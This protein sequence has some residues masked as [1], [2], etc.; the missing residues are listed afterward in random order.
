MLSFL[1]FLI[2]IIAILTSSYFI[3][4]FLKSKKFFN[5]LIFYILV[6][7]SQVIITFELLSSVKQINPTGILIINAI[8][9]IST[10]IYWKFNNS[11][12]IKLPDLH[13]VLNKIKIALKRD[14]IL[15]WLF[16]LLIVSSL[17]SLFLTLATP[18]NSA[19][20]L[21][22]HL[23]R[24]KF[25]LQNQSLLHYE[26][27][28]IRQ[29][30]FPINSEILILWSMVFLKRDFLAQLPEYLSYIGCL[31]LIF[32]FLSYLKFSTRRT[33]WTILI[34][35]SM[36]AVILESMSCQTNLIMAFLLLSSLYLF[37][38]GVKEKQKL[39]LIFS[40]I[41]YSIALGTKN[42]AFLF[43]PV[44]GIIFSSISIKENKKDFYKPLI[45]F[46]LA[47]I[48]TFIIL[49]SYNYILN[50]FDYGNPFSPS[51]FM[52]QH[53][54]GFTTKGFITNIIK[55]LFVF[56]D[57]TGLKNLEWTNSLLLSFKDNFLHLLGL[58][59]KDGL[60]FND[61][62][63]MNYLIHE[64]YSMY[65]L[66]GFI[67]YLPLVIKAIFSKNNLNKDKK[68][69]IKLSGYIFIGFLISIS[70]LMGFCLWFNRFFLTAIVLSAP[71]FVY[72]YSKENT[73]LKITITIIAGLNLIFIPVF[74]QS[75]PLLP[76]ISG[77]TKYNYT[78]FRNELRLRSD[79][80]INKNIHVSQLI[81]YLRKEAPNNSKIALVSFTEEFFYPLFE[82]NLTWKIYP[83]RYD[84]FYKRKNYN[85]YDFI[86]LPDK[87]QRITVPFKGKI[88]YKYSIKDNQIIY[89]DYNPKE[90]FIIYNDKNIKPI[91]SG[92]PETMSVLINLSEIPANFKL[93]KTF[94]TQYEDKTNL[95]KNFTYYVYKKSAI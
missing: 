61:L 80:N 86:I 41:S 72:S 20:S 50:F 92:T 91:D 63:Q 81:K 64:N 5:S 32:N 29:T 28:S 89:N 56:I 23:A 88:N 65:G 3:C 38:F 35:A 75:K 1:L 84:L 48:P 58:N 79:K 51:S 70:A 67:L 53:S 30:A 25:W 73:T 76:V 27:S 4:S 71:I 45:V 17:I 95:D 94:S 49:S 66:L 2:S 44:F 74:N 87:E 9:L 19:D 24:I 33:L 11:P 52:H 39:P 77:I 40:A 21:A 83:L 14:Q 62:R 12:L 22:Y 15:K 8:I 26:T 78:E 93:V 47:G 69:Y 54:P 59:T 7:I 68:F 36:P 55:Y 90:P 16:V 85:D 34:L 46:I 57:F 60:A 10:T 6:C 42:T 82:E 43:L 31:V 18:T 37:T 13:P